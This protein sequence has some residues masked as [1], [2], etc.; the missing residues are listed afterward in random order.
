MTAGA[1]RRRPGAVP[2]DVVPRRFYAGDP[3]AVGPLLLNKLLVRGTRVGRI[4][5][6]EAY[7]GGED[8]ASH[9]FGGPTRR[10]ATMF[11]P[12]GHLYVYFTYGMHWCANAVCGPEGTGHALLLRALAPE[13]GLA[14]MRRARPVGTADGQLTSGPAKLCQAFGIAGPEDGAD[15]VEGDRGITVRDDG[16]PPPP[17]PGV[18]GRVGIRQAT[19]RPWRWWVPGDPHV[20]RGRPGPAGPGPSDRRRPGRHGRAPGPRA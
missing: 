12:P 9:A 1:T 8:P 16:T 17:V 4:V 6:V 5:E 7:R 10:N 19:D 2:G 18:S 15:L 20:S 14:A 3:V 13:S 11:G